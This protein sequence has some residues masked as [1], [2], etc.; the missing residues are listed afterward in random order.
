MS[1][2]ITKQPMGTPTWIDLGIPDLERAI[3]F[4]SAVFG[5]ECEIGPAETGRYTIC[6]LDG[7]AV[8]A[9]APAD[10]TSDTYWWTV[11]L[12]TDDAAASAATIMEAGGEILVPPMDIMEQGRMAVARDPVGAQFGLWETHSFVG[13]EVVNEPGALLRNDL[14]T[15]NPGPAREFYARVFGFT[16][17]A[18]PDFVGDDDFTF[19]RRPDGHEIGG[20]MGVPEAPRSAWGTLFEVADTDE[21]VAK[22]RAAGGSA[23]EPYDMIYGRLAEVRDPFGAEFSIGS[24]ATS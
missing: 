9:L 14:I 11:Y 13:C 21:T 8:G 24:R 5:W 3:A 12:A 4:Y 16:N 7:R 10:G 2:V 19:L 6:R 23:D 17:D 20:I 18:N 1:Y 22:I 15:P